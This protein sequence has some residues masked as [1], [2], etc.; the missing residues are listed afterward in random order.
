[1]HYYIDGY[2][3]IFS[4]NLDT[5][6]FEKSRL[7]LIEWLNAVAKRDCLTITVVFDA[8]FQK[9]E[10]KRMHV[11]ALEVIFSGPHETADSLL[12]DIFETKK[13][14]ATITL[15]TSDH[16]LRKRAGHL[17]VHTETVASFV[18]KIKKKKPSRCDAMQKPTSSHRR[19]LEILEKIFSQARE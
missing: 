14:P 11:G 8:A 12:L 19:E 9:D 17:R 3:F 7:E 16:S 13:R 6:D 15:V 4:Q 2:N 5:E 1:M 10:R 18:Q